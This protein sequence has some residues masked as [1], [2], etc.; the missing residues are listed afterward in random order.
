MA[1]LILQ[2]GTAP[3]VPFLVGR[4]FDRDPS[5]RRGRHGLRRRLRR[6]EHN[7]C[8]SA[9]REAARSRRSHAI[10][11]VDALDC[12]TVSP[13]LLAFAARQPVVAQNLI[14][15]GASR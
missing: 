13:A 10:D 2:L 15:G 8:A 9:V 1:H 7:W 12:L 14:S 3:V 5:R 6:I 4:R 11:E